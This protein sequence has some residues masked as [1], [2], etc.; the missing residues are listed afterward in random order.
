MKDHRITVMFSVMYLARGGAEQQLLELVRAIDKTRFEPLVV[1]LYPGGP[2][3]PEVRKVPGVELICLDRKGRYDFLVL[4]KIIHLLRQ[5]KVDVIQSFITPATFFSLLPAVINRTPIRIVTERGGQ[6]KKTSLS[7]RLY[8]KAEDF[9]SHFADWVVPNSKA[10]EKYC[11]RR[12]INPSH[13][14]VIYNGL[15]LS[16]LTHD[17]ED[18]EQLRPKLGV[19]P[20]GKI[21]GIMARLSLEKDHATFLRAAAIINQTM[22]N[23]RFALLGDGPLRNYLESLS[24]ELGLASKTIFLG[25][26]QDVGTYLSTFDV[27]VLTS[28]REGCSNSLLEAMALGKPVVA[29]DVGGNRELV[30]HGETGL[31]VPFGNAEAVASAVLSLIHNPEAARA[32]GRRAREKVVSQFSLENMVQQYQSLYDETLR[33][34]GR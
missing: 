26:Q 18:M 13:I 20:E 5:R 11:I 14:K 3:E 21:V 10:G 27:A 6:K 33:Q 29:T 31:L 12:R 23:T 24:Q 2:L 9:L 17:K 15:N 4:Y 34:K 22:P 19:P 16:R 28:E 30:H 25:E 1:S 32:M 8:L 7:Y